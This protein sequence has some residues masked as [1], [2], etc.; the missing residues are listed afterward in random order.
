MAAAVKAAAFA[1]FLRV[2]IEAF[3]Q[4]GASWVAPIWWMAAITMVLGNVVALSQR[5]VKRMLAYSSIVHSGYLLVAVAA[6]TALGAAA[7]LF[8][9]FAYTLAT[10]GAFAIVAALSQPGDRNLGIVDYEG[11]WSARPGLAVAMAV[12]MLALLGFPVFG[13][14]GFFAKWYLLQA[15]LNSPH[16]LV[17]LA[18][19]LVLTS[20]VSAGYYLHVVRV[21][22]MKERPEAAVA[23]ARL[24]GYTQA[25]VA[26]T[27][28]LILALGLMPGRLAQWTMQR[29]PAP[30]KAL[31]TVKGQTASAIR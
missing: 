1:G 11:L 21:M 12:Y 30:A 6:G 2:W 10:F 3:G 24:G 17:S 9:L 26:A 7:F 23:P 15:A 4:L 16:H 28:V 20:V 31:S 13:G 5:N 29:P 14:I 8:Y 27:V 19:L 22:F 25:V 18:V